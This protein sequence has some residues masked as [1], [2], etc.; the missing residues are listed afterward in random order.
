MS[1]NHEIKEYKNQTVYREECMYCYQDDFVHICLDCYFSGCKDHFKVHSNKY[2]HHLAMIISKV[3]SEKRPEKITKL[4]ITEEKQEYMSI[5]QCQKCSTQIEND[6]IKTKIMNA[7]SNK[8]QQEMKSW[9]EQELQPCSHTELNQAG[10]AILQKSLA[11]CAECELKENLWLC[12]TCGNLGCGRQQYGGLGGNSHGIAHYEKT[13]HPIVVKMGTITPE[14][15]ADVFCY[16]HG[17]EIL[18]PNLA[19]HLQRFG[20]NIQ[21]QE[22]TAKSLLE[23]QLEQNLKF[24]FSMVTDDGVEMVGKTG[25]GF[26]GLK[27]LG[28]SCYMA[29]VFQTLFTIPQFHE[30]YFDPSEYHFSVCRNRPQ[31]CYT[32]QTQKLANGLYSGKYQSISPLMIKQII[33]KESQEFNSMR[34]QDAQEFLGFYLD[35]IEKQEK[36]SGNDPSSVFKFMLQQ[37]LQCIECEHVQYNR[38]EATG[39]SLPVPATVEQVQDSKKVYKNVE[40]LDCLS[41]Y[42]T[43]DIREF[44]CSIDKTKTSSTIVN[45]FQTFP[46]YLVF[47]MNRFVLGEGWVMEKLDVKIHVPFEIDL[48]EYKAVEQ[49]GEKLFPEVDNGPVFDQSAVDSLLQMGFSENRSKRALLNTG[50]NGVEAAMTWLFEHMDDSSLDLPLEDASQSNAAQ[51][52]PLM[53][54]GFSQAQAEYAMK[55]TNNDIERAVDWLFSHPDF[56]PTKIKKVVYDDGPSKYRLVSFISHKGTSAHC[57]HYVTCIK[58]GDEWILYNDEKVVLVPGSK[59]ADLAADAYVYVFRRIN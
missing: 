23:M 59:V 31:D 45:A 28:N 41:Q 34:Q 27:N 37:R 9:Q 1:C 12:L 14:G 47:T 40:F 42:F 22:K 17:T 58:K 54:M 3:Q 49:Q 29:S 6:A 39:I 35:L 2:G 51:L 57:G 11:S 55:Q 26:T 16:E 4:Q 13:K 52:G 18:N 46:E 19:S 15:T 50:N 24:D 10:G 36:Q 25:S 20:I 30:K 44:N 43:A 8:T 21:N 48:K 53:D 33:G 56:D 5:I 7:T 38:N 32:C